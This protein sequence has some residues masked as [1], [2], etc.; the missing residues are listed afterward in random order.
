MSTP[1]EDLIA[2]RD[3]AAAE[4]AVLQDALYVA[5]REAQ[6]LR[7]QVLHTLARRERLDELLSA[8]SARE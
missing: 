1:R 4:L 3:Q 5:N 7:D 8:E 6:S 2:Q